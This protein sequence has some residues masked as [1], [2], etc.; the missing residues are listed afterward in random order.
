[1]SSGTIV[2]I[3]VVIGVLILSLIAFLIVRRQRYVRA[4]RGHRGSGPPW[5]GC[6][7]TTLRPR[8]RLRAQ[9]GRGYFRPNTWWS[10]VPGVRVHE[11][12]WRGTV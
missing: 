10:A 6:L 8:P 5:S 9:G 1:M 11:P 4:L 3:L 12:R 7:I 2:I